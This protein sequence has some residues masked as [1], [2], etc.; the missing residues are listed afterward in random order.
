M[1]AVSQML[2]DMEDGDADIEL[3]EPSQHFRYDLCS[4]CHARFVRDPLAKEQQH[5]LYFSKN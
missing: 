4:T 1:E 3:P 2:K 5:K